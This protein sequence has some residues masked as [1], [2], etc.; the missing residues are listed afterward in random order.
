[1]VTL[2]FRSRRHNRRVGQLPMDTI[3]RGKHPQPF[4]LRPEPAYHPEPRKLSGRIWI[5]E[6]HPAILSKHYTVGPVPKDNVILPAPR[7]LDQPDFRPLPANAVLRSGVTDATI[8]V[9]C[10]PLNRVHGVIP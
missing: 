4:A 2:L 1:M 5:Q 3:T 9:P 7:V 10:V 8:R 6:H